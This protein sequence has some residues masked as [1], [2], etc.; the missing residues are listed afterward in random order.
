MKVKG[1]LQG[2]T[3]SIVLDPVEV[4]AVEYVACG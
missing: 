3:N 2:S 1:F 4:V